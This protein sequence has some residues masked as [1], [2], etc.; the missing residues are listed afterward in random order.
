M[1]RIIFKLSKYNYK[2]IYILFISEFS[3]AVCVKVRVY[4]KIPCNKMI[5]YIVMLLYY[6]LD[7][8]FSG[9]LSTQ[10]KENLFIVFILYTVNFGY[11]PIIAIFDQI[12]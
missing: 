8:S 9:G 11:I 7:F 3:F 12:F 1:T 5:R 2:Y 4:D 6:I 10:N